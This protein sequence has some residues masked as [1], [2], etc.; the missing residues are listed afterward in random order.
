MATRYLREQAIRARAA[1]RPTVRVKVTQAALLALALG[2]V[3]GF[4]I[5]LLVVAALHR[6]PL[7]A[8]LGGGVLYVFIQQLRQLAG[9]WQAAERA[10]EPIPISWELQLLSVIVTGIIFAWLR[11]LV[12]A[13]RN[14]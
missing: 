14:G 13:W 7:A 9:W 2:T 4:A 1:M 5:F 6:A 10:Q 3:A 12:A 11:V 8:V